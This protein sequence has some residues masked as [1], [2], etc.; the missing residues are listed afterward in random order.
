MV[1]TTIFKERF[2]EGAGDNASLA[3][4]GTGNRDLDNFIGNGG[5]NMP[6]IQKV[7]VSNPSDTPEFAVIEN[8]VKSYCGKHA[9]IVKVLILV[10]TPANN[11]K[12]RSYLCIMDCPDETF[13]TE[14]KGLAEAIKP[15]LKGIR[16]IQFQQFSKINKE[17]FP[18]KVTW[19]YSKLQQ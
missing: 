13:E 17:K 19:L 15:F 8:A 18:S 12:D 5:P 16:R 4:G 10:S 9:D 2:G 1:G 7:I 6:G 11:R 14:C 3:L